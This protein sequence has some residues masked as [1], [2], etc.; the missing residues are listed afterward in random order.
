MVKA[1]QNIWAVVVILVAALAAVVILAVTG[2]ASSELMT[3]I[4]S[5]VLP[6]VTILLVGGRVEGSIEQVRREVNGRFSEAIRKIPDP[7]TREE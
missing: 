6:T 5:A 3:V 4:G 7:P 1:A 2:S